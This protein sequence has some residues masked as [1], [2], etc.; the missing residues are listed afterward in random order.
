M[1]ASSPLIGTTISRLFD[2]VVL[3]FNWNIGDH[4]DYTALRVR[5]LKRYLLKLGIEQKTI[6]SHLDKVELV[7]LGDLYFQQQRDFEAHCRIVIILLIVAI[8][9]WLYSIRK[10]LQHVV[11]SAVEWL[12]SLLIPLEQKIPSLRYAFKKRLFFAFTYLLLAII[13][14]FYII[15]VNFSVL[16]SWILPRDSLFVRYS[17]PVPSISVS[18]ATLLSKGSASSEMMG[19]FGVNLGPMF[20]LWVC[21]YTKNFMEEASAEIIM[22]AKR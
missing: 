17:A 9:I 4:I 10:Y 12:Q 21:R 15:L 18:P 2:F 5:D 3:G 13:I 14:E 22:A 8:F 11:S 1:S 16:A 7:A 20:A 19:G 6:D